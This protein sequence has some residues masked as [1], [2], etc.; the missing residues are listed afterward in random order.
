MDNAPYHS[1]EHNKVPSKYATKK[2][3]IDWF[4][5]NSISARCLKKEN[6]FVSTNNTQEAQR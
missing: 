5:A 6:I 3:I 4:Q 1:K 2:E